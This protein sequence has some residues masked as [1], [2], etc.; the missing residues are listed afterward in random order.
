MSYKIEIVPDEDC[1]S[2][3]GDDC[4]LGTFVTWMRNYRSP[5]DNPWP[6]PA[7]M[8]E[9]EDYKRA[10]A[11]GLVSPVYCYIHGGTA[12]SLNPFSCP[13]DSGRAGT[14]F[15]TPEDAD[16]IWGKGAWDRDRVMKEFAAEV[17]T[18]TSWANGDCHG[19]RIVGE[20]GEEVDSCY[21]FYSEDDARAA[22]EDALACIVRHDEKKAEEET[23]VG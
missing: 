7:E 8:E 12:Y 23:N 16:E 20:D 1:E 5:D 13:W 3:R 21:G 18:Y 14:I 9:D 10:D 2:P 22:A 17:E 19:F 11:A 15:C 6:T 4:N